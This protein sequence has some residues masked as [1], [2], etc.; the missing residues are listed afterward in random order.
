M[1]Y[2]VRTVRML[3]IALPLVA[4]AAAG[5]PA[6]SRAS[7]GATDPA[8]RAAE[9]APAEPP[10]EPVAIPS[11]PPEPALGT[12]E[13]PA[14]PPSAASA[15]APAPA[16][17][18]TPATAP[19]VS[20]APGAAKG[21]PQ[22]ESVFKRMPLYF[23][24]NRGQVDNQVAFYLLNSK[25]GTFFTS[26]G[27]MFSF[28]KPQPREDRFGRGM[29]LG[30]DASRPPKI[31]DP[32]ELPD[33]PEPQRWAV[34]MDL[35]GA[36]TP[37]W[38]EGTQMQEA[39]VS[40]FKGPKENWKVALPTYTSVVYKEVWPGIDLT[41]E[42]G[43]GQMKYTFVVKPGADPS[44]IKLRYRGAESVKLDQGEVLVETPL[45][46]I[47]D[48]KP[49]VTQD[50]DG[51]RDTIPA[52]HVVKKRGKDW[53]TGFEVGPYDTGR[54]LEIDPVVTFEPPAAAR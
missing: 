7:T 48:Q 26:E 39:I 45:G 44:Q 52:K 42:G 1:R 18:A 9:P 25:A 16:T 33:P 32:N 10:S 28:L 46:G 54:P 3:R 2:H 24:E 8:P 43:T 17:T 15:A 22:V 23:V 36:R 49:V 13:K 34:A 5:L 19:A 37:L 12:I 14:T 53:V 20:A 38:P 35:L 4:A 30:A 47:R 27:V 51:C 31:E 40:Y 50:I 11:P 41:Y 21:G 6:A 29:G